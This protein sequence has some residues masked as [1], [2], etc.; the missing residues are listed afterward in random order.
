VNRRRT[1]ARAVAVA[2][3]VQS[4]LNA[5]L[6][7][8]PPAP[9]PR[10]LDGE[11]ISVLLPLRDEAARVLPC[12][13]SLTAQSQLGAAQV[14]F[15]VLDDDS[16]DDTAT[17]VEKVA[18]GEPRMRLIRGTGEPP[19]GYLGKPWACSRLAAAADSAAT[20]LVFLDGDVVL[21]PDALART[22]S[23][24]RGARLGFVSPYPR[25]VAQ[26][27]GERLVQPL[28]QWSWLTLVPLRWAERSRRPSLAIA[29]G[30][31]L[32]V[33]AIRYA[34]AGGH[35]SPSVRGAVLEDLA[36]ARA[37]RA[38]GAHGGMADG[39]D[40]AD[41]RMYESW[42]ELRDGY[43]KSLWAAAGG[44]LA[45]SIA[46]LGFLGWLYLRPDPICYA[47][48]V[49]SRLVAAR[50]TGARAFPD[51]LAHPLS[52]AALAALTASSWRGRLTGQ[53]RWKGR[54]VIALSGQVSQWPAS[55]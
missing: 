40:L 6:L 39:T 16:G 7:R 38:V 28:L 45:G 48:G 29:N 47:A 49:A 37:L 44:R 51:A 11:R 10:V 43:T 36:L 13:E 1:A 41:C 55:S 52:I 54:T 22:V 32:A 3:A 33:D 21:A 5:R 24:L 35:S 12:L 27:P 14:E 30:Q 23:L 19:P 18:A 9:D 4:A 53:L 17:I 34:Q 46:Q 42:A 2:L 20:V 15:V 31:L 50:R 8:R 26:T 25:E